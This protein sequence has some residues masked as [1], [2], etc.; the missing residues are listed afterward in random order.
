MTDLLDI[1]IAWIK[2]NLEP[3]DV[4]GDNALKRCAAYD[5][6]VRKAKELLAGQREMLDREIAAFRRDP[7]A[8]MAPPVEHRY[9]ISSCGNRLYGVRT[10]GRDIQVWNMQMA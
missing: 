1:T 2:D 5:D 9:F 10:S 4:F 6:D 7:W 8:Y 3:G